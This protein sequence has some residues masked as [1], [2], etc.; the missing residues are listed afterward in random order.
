MKSNKGKKDHGMSHTP[1]Y[2]SWEGMVQR[3]NNPN[4][5]KYRDYS[6]R[7]IKV[8]EAWKDFRVFFADMGPRPDGLTLD[9]INNNGNYEP[10]NCRW[11][12]YHE[13]RINSRPKSHV[14]SNLHFFYAHGLN[15][16]IVIWNNQREFA[17]KFGLNP[18]HVGGCLRNERKQ[19]RGWTFQWIR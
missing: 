19:H 16:E 1:A 2:S 11:A 5:K 18:S 7:G 10:G 17:I 4:N 14:S 9:R 15:G 3:C 8:C 12:T 13:Q 6:G